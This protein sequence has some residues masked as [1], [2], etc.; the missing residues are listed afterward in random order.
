MVGLDGATW[1]I[2]RPLA[3]E[4]RLPNLQKIMDH[5]A[6]GVLHSTVPPV[7]PAAWTTVFTGK[8]PG[9]HG[10][11][12]FQEIDRHTYEFRTLRTHRH[13]EKTL[14]D[15][16]GEN[17]K[18]SI[19]VDV[20]FTY[21]PHPLNGLMVTGYGTPRTPDTVF[22]YPPDFQTVL[23][24]ELHAE[25][26]IALP[27]KR[28]DR[29]QRFIDEWENV[30][31]GRRKLL[32]H[33]VSEEAWDFFMVVFSI[34]DNMAHVFW[35]YADTAHPNYYREEATAFRKAFYHSYEQCDRVLGEL[36]EAAG[37]CTTLVISDHGFG[38]VRP[39]QYMFQRLLEGRYLYARSGKGKSRV[40]SDRLLSVAVNAYGRFPFLRERIKGLQ[41]GRR[42]LVKASL[43]KA[44]VMPNAAAIDYARSRVIVSNFG[45]QLWL[46]ESGRFA[47]G[48]VDPADREQILAELTAYLLSDS[49]PVTGR[50]VV[51]AVHRG[52]DVYNGPFVDECPDLIVEYT[53]LFNVSGEQGQKNGNLEGGHT[54][55]GIILASGSAIASHKVD[56]A[57]LMD[58]APSILHLLGL[59]VPFDLDGRVLEELLGAEHRLQNPIRMS[60]EVARTAASEPASYSEEQEKEIRDQLR[61]LGYL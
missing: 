14:W 16:L 45:L 53:N 47:H 21:P 11:F 1:D 44:G 43:K 20:P 38:S 50:P 32:R 10:I 61:Q 52:R 59:A 6:H 27:E 3:G 60:D 17:G 39:R 56:N 9:R 26:R 12:D 29:S 42:E 36:M 22:T 4:G 49:D 23:P 55:D 57:S 51:L 13:R 46:N 58:L 40:L 7:T 35:T 31:V 37:D 33:L 28:F 24:P 5:G 15:L 2:I 25:I 34:T 41:P 48:P 18:R 30:M 8:N 19:L 54:H